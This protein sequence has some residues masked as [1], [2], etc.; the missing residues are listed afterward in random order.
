MSMNKQLNNDAATAV[1]QRPALEPI[2]ENIKHK[3]VWQDCYPLDNGYVFE[4][5][6]SGGKYYWFDNRKCFSLPPELVGRDLDYALSPIQNVMVVN[7]FHRN[8]HDQPALSMM[9]TK[10]GFMNTDEAT[11]NDIPTLSDVDIPM[12]DA[13][14]DLAAD[15]PVYFQENSE[16]QIAFARDGYNLKIVKQSKSDFFNRLVVEF[17]EEQYYVSV[18]HTPEIQHAFQTLHLT[19]KIHAYVYYHYYPCPDVTLV[20][21]G[22]G[23]IFAKRHTPKGYWLRPII[24][25]AM[26]PMFE[27]HYFT[28][29]SNNTHTVDYFAGLESRSIVLNARSHEEAFARF[30]ELVAKNDSNLLAGKSH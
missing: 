3:F 11:E 8:T 16:Y 6:L 5:S 27:V 12:Y 28:R 19:H 23:Q 26:T 10:V 20:A 25:E 9:A 7:L 2:L 29:S 30:E 18:M 22:D 17:E 14:A 1:A 24:Y 13:L 21:R 15:D 4:K